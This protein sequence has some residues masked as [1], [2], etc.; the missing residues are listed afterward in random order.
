MSKNEDLT[1]VLK[2]SFN[3]RLLADAQS[4]YPPENCVSPVKFLKAWSRFQDLHH[5]VP[6]VIRS[7]CSPHSRSLDTGTVLSTF[8]GEGQPGLGK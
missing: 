2:F 5:S 6:G 8:V 1:N 7:A 3:K 4:D